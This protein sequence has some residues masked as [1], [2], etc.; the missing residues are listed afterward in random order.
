M[1]AYINT[2]KLRGVL[3]VAAVLG[4]LLSVLLAI[5]PAAAKPHA[6]PSG[7]RL[8][9]LSTEWA[10]FVSSNAPEPLLIGYASR[11]DPNGQDQGWKDIATS[12]FNFL[13]AEN[14]MKMDQLQPSKGNFSFTAGDK[15]VDY[16]KANGMKVHGHVLVWDEQYPN[17][18]NSESNK[19]QAMED[20]IAGVLNHYK[21]NRHV[22]V[23]DVVNE[24]F[25][26]DGTYLKTIWYNA[27]GKDFVK[28]AFQ[29]AASIDSTAKLIYN[30]YN[31]AF[32]SLMT[33]NPKSEATFNMIRDLKNDGVKIDGVGFQMHLIGPD[34]AARGQAAIDDFRIN[35]DRFA[36]L[37]LEIYITELDVRFPMPLD[38]NERAQ[39]AEIY[40]WIVRECLA[41]PAC[42]GIQTWGITDKYSWV[43]NVFP[44]EGG[45][46]PFDDNYQPKPA[47]YAMQSALKDAVGCRMYYRTYSWNN[48][49][50]SRAY[51]RNLS[52]T[53]INGWTLTWDY[54][55]GQTV[56]TAA[57]TYEGAD[58]L[59]QSGTKVTASGQPS[60]YTGNGLIYGGGTGERELRFQGSGSTAIPTGPFTLNG[61]Q[62]TGPNV[63]LG[64]PT[65]LAGTPQGG[66][67]AALTWTLSTDDDVDQYFLYRNNSYIATL[68][69]A[70]T[71]FTDKSL[72]PNVSY[73]YVLYAWDQRHQ[74]RSA[75]S[76]KA[77]VMI[78][79]APPPGVSVTVSPPVSDWGSGYCSNVT[80]K[81]NTGAPVD[82]AVTFTV[83]GTIYTLWNAIWSQ[84]GNTV[85][86]EGV[87]WNNILQPGESSHSIGFCANR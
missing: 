48:V 65:N 37:G 73:E 30:D 7:K 33:P 8:K 9:V 4:L 70:V 49:T 24:V 81:N 59:S 55:N 36:N 71:S 53:T 84:S 54:A 20:H 51:I 23:W 21:G 1:K 31:I 64:P 16:A 17:W 87:G 57:G 46:L 18:M 6:A 11:G 86:A 47:Y 34:V 44:G 29:K 60:D 27:M 56:N 85:A 63:P 15:H 28:Y 50:Y 19:R 25:E 43:P 32:N 45:A 80:V 74:I 12:E 75:P 14:D 39:Q 77:T 62:C 22:D 3:V 38:N 13:T 79:P 10:S 76:N 66:N 68:G 42:K 35:M 82:W 58:S 61:V 78:N 83:D 26:E 5:S 72:A 69:R 52:V 67:S 40:G 41:Q 2:K